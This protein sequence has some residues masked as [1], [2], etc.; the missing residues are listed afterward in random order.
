[1]GT[2]KYQV[3]YLKGVT[4]EYRHEYQ[5]E[6]WKESLVEGRL[7]GEILSAGDFDDL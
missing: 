4:T 3:R 2:N 1:M 6:I 5:K 7:I